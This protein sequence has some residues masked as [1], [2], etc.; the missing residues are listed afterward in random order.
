MAKKSDKSYFLEWQEYRDNTRKSTPI[1]RKETAAEKAKRIARLEKNEEDWFAYYF[2]NFYTSKP[3]LFH[4]KSTKRVLKHLEWYEVRSWSRELSKSGRTMMEVL[5]L[6]LTGKKKNILM[7]SAT[8]DNACRLLLPYKSILE[9]NNRIINDYGIQE[10]LTKWEAG[11]FVTKK[12]ASF[13]AIGAGQSPRGTR[14]DE[15]RPDTILI[16]DIDTDEECRNPDR[17]KAKIKWIEEALMPTRSIS[18]HLLVIVCGNIIAKFCCVTELAKKADHHDIINIRDKEGKSTWPNKNSEEQIDRVLS[19]ISYNSAQ[20][21]YFNNP[22]AEGDVFKSIVF[23]K[24]PPLKSCEQVLIYTDPATSNKDKGNASTK[25]II[26]IGYKNFKY[27]V[28]KVWLDT[29]RNSKFVDCMFEA[30]D[31]LTANGV[32]V[33]RVFIENNSLQ[34]PFYEQVIYPLIM[35]VAKE[36]GYA[37][38]ITPDTRKKPEKFYRI[39]GTLEPIHRAGNLVFNIDEKKNP[40]MERLEGQFL[41]VSEKAKMMDGPDCVEGGVWIIKNRIT[42]SGNTYSVGFRRNQRY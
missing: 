27:Y 35:A 23:E 1:D 8:Y 33:K 2:P 36:K 34:D 13:R 38:P 14:K 4:L 19:K 24:C 20:K 16:D 6:V 17:I 30:H 26:V 5:Y 18:S 32:D 40:N 9:S 10:S 39:E 25:A 41:G 29:M 42:I 3:A 15:V 31:Y 21:E 11:E 28:Y 22:V 12:G 7:V 37:L